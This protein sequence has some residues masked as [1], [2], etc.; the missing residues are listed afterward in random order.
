MRLGMQYSLAESADVTEH[1]LNYSQKTICTHDGES[2]S[3][4]VIYTLHFEVATL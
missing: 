3:N 4:A 1:E 2:V